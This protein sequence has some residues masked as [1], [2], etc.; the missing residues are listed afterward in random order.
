VPNHYVTGYHLVTHVR[1]HQPAG[2]WGQVMQTALDHFYLPFTFSRA[3]RRVTGQRL[4]PA[5]R[6]MV[7]ELDSLWRRQADQ[8]PLTPATLLTRRQDDTYTDYLYPQPLA[9]G[10]VIALKT[11]L[12]HIP[13]FVRLSADGATEEKLFTPGILSNSPM[14]SVAANKIVWSE[15]AYDRRWETRNYAVIKTYDLNT[16]EHRVLQR[17]TRLQAPALAPD[18]LTI[19]AIDV[20][21]SNTVSL[22]ILEAATGRQLKRIASPGNDFISMPRWSPDGRQV[23]LLRTR[24]EERTISL[25]DIGT[26]GFTDL[27]PYSAENIGHP[28]LAAGKVYYNSPYNG[29]ENI[30]VLDLATKKRYQVASRRY[31]GIN[32]ALT[33]AGDTLFFNDFSSRGYNVAKMANTPD[34]WVPLAQ[35]P[36][37]RV[38]LFAPLVEQEGKPDILAQVPQTEYPVTKYRPVQHLFNFHSWMPALDPAHNTV[39]L[40]LLSQDLLSTL[41]SSVGYTRN[42]SE[43]SGRVTAGLRYQGWFPVLSLEGSAGNRVAGTAAAAYHWQEKGLS[44][45]LSLPLN[46]TNSRYTEYLTLSAN[47]GVTHISDY[48]RGLRSIGDQANGVLR[49]LNYQVSYQHSL[50]RSH[51]DLAGR[52]AQS[53]LLHLSHTPLGGDYRSRLLAAN[54]RLTFPGLLRHHSLQTWVNFQDQDLDNYMFSSPLRFPRGYGYPVHDRFHSFTLQYAFP[55]WYPDLALGPL[56]YFQRLKGNV[57]YDDGQTT[58]RDRRTNLERNNYYRSVGLEL[59][60][61]F[62]VMRLSGVVLDAGLRFSYLLTPRKP[63][64]EVILADLGF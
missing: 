1:R 40:A 9:D 28:V 53:A 27:L 51:R 52:F 50:L 5:Y 15:I 44:G 63:S 12:S 33:P 54:V 31:A 64:L 30:Y 16:G 58:F 10:R 6:N 26:G 21:T 17:K 18:G 36:V 56:L 55:L 2:V 48:S 32:P 13:V 43:N 62:N 14:L 34:A 35:A 22:L 4:N 57:F 19:A 46:F 61:N 60:T 3:M 25:V 59:T 42:L 47:A 38:D 11:G 7:G 24:N 29:I 49:R 23:V 37:Q 41:V 20:D 39:S 8:L 45:G